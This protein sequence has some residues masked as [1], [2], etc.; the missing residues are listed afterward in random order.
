MSGIND[1]LNNVGISEILCKL[2]RKDCW[3]GILNK[4]MNKQILTAVD[5]LSLNVFF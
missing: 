5:K 2:G 4:M 1:R 3:L